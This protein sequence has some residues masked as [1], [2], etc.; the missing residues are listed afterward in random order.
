MSRFNSDITLISEANKVCDNLKLY[1][2][3]IDAGNHLYPFLGVRFSFWMH[4]TCGTDIGS[5]PIDM[6]MGNKTFSLG[7][8]PTQIPCSMLIYLLSLT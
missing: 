2:Q 6:D 4:F 3:Y 8:I 5:I 1:L 7:R